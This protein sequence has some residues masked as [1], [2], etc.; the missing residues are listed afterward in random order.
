MTFDF[1]KQTL[2]LLLYGFLAWTAEVVYFAV[3]KKKFVNRGLLSLPIDFEIGAV[4]SGVAFILPTLGRNYFGMYLITLADL[5]LV[6]SV[7]GFFCG[8]LTKNITWLEKA[9]SGSRRNLLFNLL[10]AG[11]I[12]VVY[13][14][15]QP[16][17][18][19]LAAAL[20]GAVLTVLWV[21]AWALIAGNF[22]AV[23]FAMRKGR[24]SFE[25]QREKGRAD[26]LSAWISE[27]VWKRL[28]KAYPGIRDEDRRTEISFAK[29]MS[30][31]KLIWVF[32]ISALLGDVI[33]TLYCRLVGGTW[34]S[35]SS[36]IFG[37]FSFVWGVGAVLLTVSLN[38][39][40]DKNDRWILLAGGI[41]GGAFEYMCSLFTELVFGKV[42][43][44]YSDMPLNIGGRTN[45]LFMFF[46]GILGLVWVKIVYPPLERFIEK[47]PPVA[48]K[49]L[50]WVIL[51]LTVLNG[52]FTAAVL[53]R[54]NER[55]IGEPPSNVLE[56]FIDD[57]YDDAF[58]EHRWQ[59]MV[60]ADTGE[61]A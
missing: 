47:A 18:L 15:L 7:V 46:W 52:L 50:T 14:L 60:S 37:P 53:Q 49:V 13:L 54:Y 28:E 23:V 59:N 31:D 58:V 45:L 33:E 35:R 61:S 9:P 2:F 6:R 40:K 26:R 5:V 1:G 27:T 42:F 11:A 25:R 19:V 24:D 38:R 43:W 8:R 22:A 56:E 16:V 21:A 20:P 48:A 44:D 36:V 3:R 39:L 32:L 30:L 10:A 57:T 41:L 12:L 4:F 17:F 51:V 34:M 29:G 55:Q